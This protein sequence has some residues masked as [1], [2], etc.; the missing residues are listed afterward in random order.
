MKKNNFNYHLLII[1][2]SLLLCGI[3]IV[4]AQTYKWMAVGSLHNW[5]S[6]MGCEIEVGRPG[7]P[8][9]QDGLQWPAILRK[10]DSQCAKGL[11]LG[12]KNFTDETGNTYGYKVVHIG[13]RTD[14]IGEVFPEYFEMV[15][16]FDPP[17]V[18]VDDLHSY[19]K[20][21][22]NDD[23]DPDLDADRII[24]NIVNT[25]LGVTIERTI[26][27][28]SHP[29]HDNY[30]IYEYTYTNTG[31]VDDDSDIE[32]PN[33]TVEDFYVFYQYR[34]SPCFQ[35]RYVIG[36]ASGWG[37]S[38]MHDA[39]GDGASNIAIYNDP[40]DER[41]RAQYTWQ[42]YWSGRDPQHYDN[43]GGPIWEP[44]SILLDRGYTTEDDSV[45]RLA[46]PQFVGNVTLYA[47][48]PDN[49]GV[50]D[51]NQPSTT[52]WFGSNVE[53]TKNNDPYNEVWMQEEYEMMSDQHK[54]PRHAWA[55]EP[56]GN[57][58]NQQ[59]ELESPAGY[60]FGNGYGP[61]TLGSG[62]SITIVMAEA[63]DG[64]GTEQCI[65][66]GR[67]YKNGQID[68]VAKNIWVLTG[69][70]SLFKTF[71][72][73]I[74]NYASGYSEAQ[75]PKPPK[76]FNIEGGG[77]R[78][79]LTWDIY[80]NSTDVQSYRIYRNE[81]EFDNPYKPPILVYE[82]SASE[83]RFDDLTPIRGI[84]YYYFI[85]TVDNSGLV[86]NR[87]YT[88]S[89]DPAFLVRPAGKQMSDVRVV[90]NPFIL[91]SSP[92]RL[93]FG[94]SEPD[95]LAF[96][97]IPGQCTIQIFTET[98]ELVYTIEHTNGSGDEYWKGVN[99]S[100]Q[101]VVSGIYIA[102]IKDNITGEKGLVKFVVIR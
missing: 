58:A 102:V 74:S 68:A 57:F 1:L 50:D 51:V 22:E 67:Q 9:Q 54:S 87:H 83:R 101:V 34:Y 40:L 79:I 27:A 14:G 37:I 91:S 7:S 5:F 59:S 16:K 2:I 89:F 19:G 43:I 48:D 85:Q 32:L 92:N 8:S 72:N 77:D 39:R 29:D 45:G 42:G 30:M 3:S 93:R 81:G 4:N 56:T 46:A 90:P 76:T 71:R 82:A 64:L 65:D 20:S 12:T 24:Y 31:N 6:Q 60:S 41:F 53:R 97:N 66:I 95:K 28:F 99:Y 63:A 88:Q 52:N 38:A 10:Q 17:R 26:L 25:Q 96:F 49:I 33:N 69:K 73:A 21:V 62:E 44:N 75:A 15:S 94:S 23:V 86:S 36:N 70:D 18:F 78:I 61:Y 35:P 98:G 84:G 47:D 13:P 55:A 80:D 100:N 11:W